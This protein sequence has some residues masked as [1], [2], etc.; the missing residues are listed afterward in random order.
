MVLSMVSDWLDGPIIESKN[1][2]QIIIK[3]LLIDGT[4]SKALHKKYLTIKFKFKL[5]EN[6]LN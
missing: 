4:N 6:K 1:Q 2:N 3:V 5:F